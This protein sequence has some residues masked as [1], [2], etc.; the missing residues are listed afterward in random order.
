MD[1]NG[2]WFSPMLLD[3]ARVVASVAKSK[4]QTRWGF[5]LILAKENCRDSRL[6]V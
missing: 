2:L 6:N 1:W 4:V 3:A 5:I